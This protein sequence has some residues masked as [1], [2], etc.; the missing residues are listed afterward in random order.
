MRITTDFVEALI[1]CETETA[2]D[3]SRFPTLRSSRTSTQFLSLSQRRTTRYAIGNAQMKQEFDSSENEAEFDQGEGT[4]SGAS[5]R[6]LP[7]A[8]PLTIASLLVNR[9]LFEKAQKTVA[10][11]E[12]PYDVINQP[13]LPP[14]VR[15]NT[16]PSSPASLT[17]SPRLF[18]SSRPFLRRQR[19]R[20]FRL[21][22]P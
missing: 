11:Q 3:F 1:W 15:R 13:K 16:L 17:L 5:Y 8:K 22:Q 19:N 2:I 9:V 20:S 12:I 6:N 21:P 10:T 18:S 14:I 7:G 4:S